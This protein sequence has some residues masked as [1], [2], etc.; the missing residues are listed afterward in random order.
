MSR[1]ASSSTAC[2]SAK[3]KVPI[4]TVG[5][6]E[7]RLPAS[8]RIDD[9]QA[10]ETARP[11]DKFPIRVPVVGSGLGEEEFT[12]M[13]EATRVKDASGQPVARTKRPTS[14][15][16]SGASSKEPAIIRRTSSSSR[17]TS[18]N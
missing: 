17:S 8:I 15:A 14:S 13:L 18:R 7:Y 2:S 3:K 6:G 11:D 9:L 12:V 1:S 4:F 16:P 5:V 10:P